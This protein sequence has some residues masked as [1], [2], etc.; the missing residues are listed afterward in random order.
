MSLLPDWNNPEIVLS[1]PTGAL[2][3]D[4][5]KFV[6]GEVF[7]LENPQTDIPRIARDP[8]LTGLIDSAVQK[9]PTFH[10]LNL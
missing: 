6:P 1:P 5:T 2:G 8:R 4:L 9:I 10:S 3:V 7:P